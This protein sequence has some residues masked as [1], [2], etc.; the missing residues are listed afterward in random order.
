[1]QGAEFSVIMTYF[2]K[3]D[4][5]LIYGDNKYIWNYTKCK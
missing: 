1:M 3:N 5:F 4:Q 2:N